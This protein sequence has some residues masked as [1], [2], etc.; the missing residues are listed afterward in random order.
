[1]PRKFSITDRDKK[2]F[3]ITD[4]DPEVFKE[5]TAKAEQKKKE[6]EKKEQ[7]RIDDINLLKRKIIE[8]Q[9]RIDQLEIEE[10]K[11]KEEA[12]KAEKAEKELE[13]YKIHLNKNYSFK[14]LDNEIKKI[15]KT[16]GGK[17][18]KKKQLKLPKKASTKAKKIKKTTKATKGI[19][20][21]MNTLYQKLYYYN[22]VFM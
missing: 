7:K 19:K 11:K 4:T 6:K 5:I 15:F 13:E 21:R 3:S 22:K 20:Q 12:K 10:R 8:Y 16:N 18:Q 1:M 17:L 9:N 2:S 14:N